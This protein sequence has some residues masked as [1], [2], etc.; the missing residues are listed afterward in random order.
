MD[1]FE[2]LHRPFAAGTEQKLMLLKL[3]NLQDLKAL[4]YDV[5]GE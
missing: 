5:L 3:V 1:S 2:A 4:G